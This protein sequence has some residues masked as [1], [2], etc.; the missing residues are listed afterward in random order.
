MKTELKAR[1]NGHTIRPNG[2]SDTFWS[3]AVPYRCTSIRG[4]CKNVQRVQTPHSVLF[5]GRW[6]R[7]YLA[8]QRE[9][10]VY[11]IGAT[12]PGSTGENIRVDYIP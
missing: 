5:N 11:Y 3:L 12:K 9:R 7:V 6:R 10:N 8:V 2:D 4:N 1:L